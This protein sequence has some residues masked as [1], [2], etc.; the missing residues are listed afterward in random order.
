MSPSRKTLVQR[1]VDLLAD[2]PVHTLALARDVLRLEGHPGAASAAVFALIGDDPR[3]AV[4]AGGL[5]S[6]QGDPV[7]PSLDELRFAVV[8]VETTGGRAGGGDRI[9]DIA[10]VEV[11]GGAV[12][13]EFT[14]LVNPGRTIP[15][16]IQSLTGIDQA[17]VADAPFF[18]HVAPEVQD[19]LRGRVFVAHNVGFDLGF[20]R[21]ELQQALGEAELGAALCTVRMA[22]GLLPRLRR[23]NL[24]ALTQHYGITIHARHR[25][26]GDALATARVLIRLLDEAARQGSHDLK[27]LRR[28]LRRRNRRR[29]RRSPQRTL[30][31]D[32][33]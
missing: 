28:N 26:H 1:V 5:W 24:D 13:D 20:V 3:F 10:I 29:S 17:M 31:E 19:R 14:T 9:T 22:R 15:R 25:A 21:A 16:M 32:D 30:W 23:R 11:Q 18:E 2:G 12:V 6:M 8:D 7:G 27:S 33:S 4:D